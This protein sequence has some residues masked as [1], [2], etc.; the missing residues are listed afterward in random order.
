MIKSIYNKIVIHRWD[1][2]FI[3]NSMDSILSGEEPSVQRVKSQYRD[4][5]FADPFILDYNDEEI[6]LLVEDYSDSDKKGKISKLL[7]DRKSLKLK[8]VKIIFRN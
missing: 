1:L 5:W 8:D 2:G 4:R 7:I 3:T 6:I